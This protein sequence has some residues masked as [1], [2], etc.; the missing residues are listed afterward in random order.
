MWL[1]WKYEGI[2][3]GVRVSDMGQSLYNAKQMIDAMLELEAKSYQAM[4][5]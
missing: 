5:F 4:G 2:Q 1:Q 3:Y